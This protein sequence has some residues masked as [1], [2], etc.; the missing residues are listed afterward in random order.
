MKHHPN[1]GKKKPKIFKTK[2]VRLRKEGRGEI[3]RASRDGVGGG[4]WGKRSRV[5]ESGVGDVGKM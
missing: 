1:D 2:E 4:K 3:T 5:W